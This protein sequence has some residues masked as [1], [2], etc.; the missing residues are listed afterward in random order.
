LRNM[1]GSL[2][3]SDSESGVAAVG[4]IAIV[5]AAVGGAVLGVALVVGGV[6][7]PIAETSGTTSGAAVASAETSDAFAVRA[8]SGDAAEVQILD[9]R[10]GSPIG[11]ITDGDSV[12][13]VGKDSS[14]DWA[15]IRRP[16]ALAEIGWLPV[17][18]LAYDQDLAVLPVVPCVAPE[19]EAIQSIGET[20]VATTIPPT[21]TTVPP[22]TTIPP[23]DTTV[24][25]ATTIPPP[26][27]EAPDVEDL[28]VLPDVIYPGAGTDA[29]ENSSA[30]P[31]SG[32]AYATVVNETDAV[33][34]TLTWRYLPTNYDY[35]G[36]F[37]VSVE[38]SSSGFQL[39]AA[40]SEL[41]QA[42][43]FGISAPQIRVE[44]VWTVVDSSGNSTT[45]V[46]TFDLGR[47]V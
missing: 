19:G 11:P 22:V 2:F 34:A 20:P 24:P 12:F 27:T 36:S 23:P 5:A 47:C 6:V 45:I 38:P 9:C 16:G 44:L 10:E 1:W 33:T 21:D 15:A 40:I 17:S 28:I 26:D 39:I 25:P 14:G 7:D 30:T 46:D 3:V 35:S 18:L 43:S 31:T 13:L 32:T 4:L 41:P 29:C 37:S 42:Y 8:V